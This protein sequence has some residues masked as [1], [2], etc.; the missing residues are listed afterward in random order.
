MRTEC[1]HDAGWRD[2]RTVKDAVTVRAL[3]RQDPGPAQK[4]R[5]AVAGRSGCR[6][7]RAEEAGWPVSACPAPPAQSVRQA[8][9]L[10]KLSLG[11]VTLVTQ[12]VSEP[13]R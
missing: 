13:E 7:L 2:S 9:L 8:L 11:P 3:G 1:V 5:P 4:E 12:K 6:G 10:S